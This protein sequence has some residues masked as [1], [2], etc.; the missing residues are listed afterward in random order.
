MRK[1]VFPTLRFSY[2]S[3]SDNKLKT[4]FLYCLIFSE[5]H[6]ISNRELIELWIVHNSYVATI[7]YID[8]ANVVNILF[9]S[10]MNNSIFIDIYPLVSFHEILLIHPSCLSSIN[11]NVDLTTVMLELSIGKCDEEIA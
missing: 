6:D 10:Y 9:K 2:D 5:D 8:N 11:I 4:C 1:D 3:L 7:F